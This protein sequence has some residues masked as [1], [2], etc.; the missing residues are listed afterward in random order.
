[1]AQPAGTVSLYSSTL[2]GTKP[3]C[4][5]AVEA[6]A[7]GRFVI[8]G[9]SRTDGPWLTTTTIIVPRVIVWPSPASGVCEMMQPSGTV[10][11][12]WRCVVASW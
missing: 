1:M 5:T 3:A 6:W 2:E 8:S 9:S 11:L 10:S 7:S 12:N 4:E